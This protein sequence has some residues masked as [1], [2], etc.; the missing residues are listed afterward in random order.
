[1]TKV[2]GLTRLPCAFLLYYQYPKGAAV[3]LLGETSKNN[4]SVRTY[5]TSWTLDA[6]SGLSDYGCL[7]AWTM[8]ALTVGLWTTGRLESGQQDAQVMDAWTLDDG[9]LGLW[10]TGCLGSGRLDSRLT[11]DNYTFATKE[12]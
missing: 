3:S 6:C 1:M 7:E 4:V 2:F 11:F 5:Q 8:N 12:I 10:T 9:T